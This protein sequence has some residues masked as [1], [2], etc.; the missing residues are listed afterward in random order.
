MLVTG[1]FTNDTA[2]SSSLC[3]VSLQDLVKMERAIWSA[4]LHEK[5]YG[6]LACLSFEGTRIETS[7]PE[8]STWV[9]VGATASLIMKCIYHS[10]HVNAGA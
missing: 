10:R 1:P 5:L 2:H 8:L 7:L 6:E 3:C 4:R 9:Q